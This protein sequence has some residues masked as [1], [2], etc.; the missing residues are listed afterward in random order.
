ME[1]TEKLEKD[2]SVALS[3]QSPTP[4]IVQEERDNAPRTG[5]EVL[6]HIERQGNH[7]FTMR[8][9][10]NGNVVKNVTRASA[11]KLWHYAINRYDEIRANFDPSTVA[12]HEDMG[13]LRKYS[14]GS[15]SYFDLVQRSENSYRF[16]FGVTENGIHGPWKSVTGEDDS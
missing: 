11:R 9:L 3:Q 8:D 7:Y 5:V 16:F 15:N 6:N 1:E 13:L 10:R 12:W 4:P 2:E 14:Q